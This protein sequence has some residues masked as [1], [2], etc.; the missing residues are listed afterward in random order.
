MS[1]IWA[2]SFLSLSIR[3][4]IFLFSP[5]ISFFSASRCSLHLSPLKVQDF[6]YSAISLLVV[7]SNSSSLAVLALRFAKLVSIFLTELSIESSLLSLAMMEFSCSPMCSILLRASMI[8]SFASCSLLVLSSAPFARSLGFFCKGEVSSPEL[9]DDLF[10]RFLI[11]F[12]NFSA[13][14]SFWKADGF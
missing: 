6:F 11:K 13:M 1:F 9:V 2:V 3:E 10:L 8:S 14:K 5:S 12:D 7:A 4:V